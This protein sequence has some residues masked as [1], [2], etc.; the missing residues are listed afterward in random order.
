MAG[1]ADGLDQDGTNKSAFMEIQQQGLAGMPHHAQAYPIR[2]TYS[3]Q[4]SQHEAVFASAHNSRPLGANPFP[5]NYNPLNSSLHNAHSYPTHP[6]LGSYPGNVPGCPPCPSPPRDATSS[7]VALQS[8]MMGSAP[9][10]YNS[11][12]IKDEPNWELGYYDMGVDKS[13]LEETLRVNGKGKKMRKPR[14][15]YSSLQLQQLNRRFQRTQ[16]LALPERAELAASL[17]LTQTQ[18]KIWFQNRRSKYKKMLKAQQ[19]QQNSQQPNQQTPGSTPNM[20]Q[21]PNPASTPHTPPESHDAHSPPSVGIL[22]PNPSAQGMPNATVSPPAMSPPISSWDMA[23]SKAA[24][25][26]VTN[27]YMPQYS[28]YH[29]TDPS[30][31]QQIL[32]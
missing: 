8:R 13:Q 7:L 22:P 14:T 23:S 20:Q 30:M 26:N 25:M 17:G 24:T 2:S 21:P 9:Y 27:T 32:T 11:R 15:I 1:A 29:N 4:P 19:N 31:S 16:Y 18:V 28:W 3:S 5:M 6:Y 10:K 12:S